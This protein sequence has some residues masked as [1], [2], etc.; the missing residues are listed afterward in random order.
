[1][2]AD[3]TGDRQVVAED[4]RFSADEASF[5]PDGRLISYQSTRSGRPEIYLTRFPL[6]DERWQVSPDGG[7]QA[8]WSD[9]GR[10]LYYLELSGRLMRVAI[11]PSAP[12]SSGRAEPMFDLGIGPPS[13]LFEHMLCRATASW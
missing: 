9:D 3:G 6:T 7:L 10:T 13:V 4:G 2:A 11:Q 1:M 12:E 8:R 5:S